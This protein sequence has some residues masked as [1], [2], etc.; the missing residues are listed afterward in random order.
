MGDPNVR[1]ETNA[2]LEVIDAKV[3]FPSS[4]V[5]QNSAGSL[6]RL[7]NGRLILAFL[8]ADNPTLRNDGVVMLSFSDDNGTSWEKPK[9]VYSNSGWRCLPMGGLVKFSDHLIR[10]IVG[11]V[12]VDKS[13][14]GDEPFSHLYTTHIES[15]DKGQSWS[16]PGPNISIFPCWTEMYGA[17]NPH[18]LSDGRYM[19]AGMGT[20]GRDDQWHAGVTFTESTTFRLTPPIIIAQSRDRNYSDIDVVRLPDDRF[21]AVIREHITRQSFSAYSSDEGR[22]WTEVRPTGFK[23]ANIKL[24][25]L[26]SGD[27]ICSYRDEDPNRRGISCSVSQ[28]SGETWNLIGQLYVAAP[29]VVHTPMGLCGYP[30]M[31]SIGSD[32]IACVLHTYHDADASVDLHFLRLKDLT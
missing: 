28:D 25:K 23:G 24:F 8:Q 7:V 9:A 21:L 15:R 11:G 6:V 13:L 27:I 3:L 1:L 16:E 17:S 4:K 12:K 2:P 20:V 26:R 18:V 10:L 30:D 32:E 14:G 5:R 31:I 22:T 19:L 29:N